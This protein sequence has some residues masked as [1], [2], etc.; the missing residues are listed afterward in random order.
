MAD[1]TVT[2][3]S[4]F[5][6]RLQCRQHLK[7]YRFSL[8]AVL[9]ANFI[10]PGSADRVLD[11][12]AG[13]GVISLILAFK[14]PEVSLTA[15]EIQEG[16]VTLALENVKLNRFQDRIKLIRGD[17]RRIKKMLAPGSFDWVVCNP[18][19]GKIGSGRLNLSDEAVIARH[20]IHADLSDIA[21]A[22]SF[23]LRTRGR[24]ALIYP[25]C[26]A[27]SLIHRIK[28]QNLEPKRLQV[29]YSYPRSVG[30]LVLVEVVKGGG[31]ELRIEEPF[32]VYRKKGGEYS[33][34]MRKCYEAKKSLYP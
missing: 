22:V 15:L 7:G 10:R 11:L 17:L 29:V 30:K 12:G 16:L 18:P 26:R 8:D 19:Y 23:T 21:R 32:Y 3:D 33:E 6:G 24:A 14:W 27:A 28:E 20:E 9:L 1:R 5:D 13:C 31:E 34:E 25:A 2:G 4:L